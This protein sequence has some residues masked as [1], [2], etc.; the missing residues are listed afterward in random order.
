MLAE[1]GMKSARATAA[2]AAAAGLLRLHFQ[3]AFIKY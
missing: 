1:A 3:V 2:A